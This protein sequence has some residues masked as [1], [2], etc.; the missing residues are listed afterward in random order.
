MTDTA[1]PAAVKEDFG[2]PDTW[3]WPSGSNVL[4]PEDDRF[5]DGGDDPM[6]NESAWWGFL[7][8]EYNLMAG[9]HFHHRPNM[10]LLWQKVLLWDGKEGVGEQVYDCTYYDAFQIQP[11]SLANPTGPFDFSSA[12]GLTVRT[13]ETWK[14]YAIKYQYNGLTMDLEFEA[15]MPVFSTP[16]GGQVRGWGINNYQQAGRMQGIIRL[17]GAEIAV[18]GPAHRDR[19]WGPRNFAHG[20]ETFLRHQWPWAVSLEGSGLV[21]NLTT[22]ADQLPEPPEVFVPGAPIKTVKPEFGPER[23]TNGLLYRDGQVS[24]VTQG[25]YDILARRDDGLPSEVVMY[26]TDDLGRTFRA[27][28]TSLNYL[29]RSSPPGIFATCSLVEWTFENGE[30]AYGQL[31]EVLPQDQARR[32]FRTLDSK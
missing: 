28:G 30:K 21:A 24:R 5:H 17:D 4:K 22:V 16:Y 11:R 29:K 15:I 10:N 7:V 9:I 2:A 14:R 18:D 32:Y 25:G 13:I 26:G 1:S 27:E 31:A 6:W 3:G 20:P 23:V 8:P 19:S 12:L